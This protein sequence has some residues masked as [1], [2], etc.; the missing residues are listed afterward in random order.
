MM[1]V[2][3]M[4]RVPY[5]PQAAHDQAGRYQIPVS[6]KGGTSQALVDSGCNQT[7][8]HQSLIQPWI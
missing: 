4:I 8:I 1:D 5:V 3:T 6:I 2:G 7:S